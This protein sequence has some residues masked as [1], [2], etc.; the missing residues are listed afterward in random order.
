MTIL[1]SAY[2]KFPAFIKAAVTNPAIFYENRI[3]YKLSL[4]ELFLYRPSLP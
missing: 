3:S 1:V 2:R 4:K